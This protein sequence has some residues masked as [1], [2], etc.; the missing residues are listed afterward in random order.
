MADMSR[1]PAGLEPACVPL[2]PDGQAVD[3]PERLRAL[4]DH[5]G[6]GRR[7]DVHDVVGERHEP[8]PF[9]AVMLPLRMSLSSYPPCCR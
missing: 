2:G 7:V 9:V 4:A 3:H 5:R 6:N 8:S 1:A